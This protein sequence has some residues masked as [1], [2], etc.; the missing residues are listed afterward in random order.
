MNK[1]IITFLLALSFYQ[2]QLFCENQI[3]CA[4]QLQHNLNQIQKIPEARALINSI[5]KE[6]PIQI[7]VKNT[8]LSNHFGAYWDPDLR[9]ICVAISSDTTDGSLIGSILFEL[10]NAAVNAKFIHLDELA[11]RRQIGKASYVESMEY[12]EYLNSIDASKIAQKGIQMGIFP[13]DAHLFTY[14]SFAEHFSVQKESGHSAC[15]AR[16]YDSIVRS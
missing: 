8:S 4:P 1:L 7:V 5:Q 13:A 9:T 2:T 15:F 10:H 3:R 16:N 6:G 12:L 11:A 14:G